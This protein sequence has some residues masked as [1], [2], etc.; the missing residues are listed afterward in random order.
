[1]PLVSNGVI[2]DIFA[3]S[4]TGVPSTAA[5]QVVIQILD[6][7]GVG[8]GG[9]RVQI[10]G[11]EFVAY[12]DQTSWISSLDR[13]TASGLAFVG[14]LPASDFPGQIVTITLTGTVQRALPARIA[15]GA[16]TVLRVSAEL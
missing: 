12:A 2:E 16:V 15:Q 6:T 8:I 1:M 10:V 14:N 7:T 11:A 13:T 4:L 5:A 3:S 9:V